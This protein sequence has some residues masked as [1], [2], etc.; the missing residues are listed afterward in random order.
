MIKTLLITTAMLASLAQVSDAYTGSPFPTHY[1]QENYTQ[2][3]PYEQYN[4]MWIPYSYVIR[5][6]P[7]TLWRASQS[8]YYDSPTDHAGYTSK[9]EEEWYEEIEYLK[10]EIEEMK[11]VQNTF[12]M[13]YEMVSN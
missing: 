13:D 3:L 7:M 2:V 6:L 4:A 8:N 10:G 5:P 1:V 11:K 12:S 9:Y